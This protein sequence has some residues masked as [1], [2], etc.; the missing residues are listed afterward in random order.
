MTRKLGGAV[1]PV[2]HLTKNG[3]EYTLS[4]ESTFKHVVIKFKPGVEFDQETPDG[5]MVKSVITVDGN[6]L[7]EIQKGDGKETTIDRIFS[8]DE[9]VMVLLLIIYQKL[10]PFYPE[11]KIFM[12][13]F[14]FRK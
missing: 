12:F 1:S 13:F 2:V 8:D 3:D 4:S 10:S 11:M 6:T 9:I 14:F 5:R 7:H